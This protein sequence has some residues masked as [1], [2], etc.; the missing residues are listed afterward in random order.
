MLCFAYNFQHKFLAPKHHL[1]KANFYAI[2]PY[3]MKRAYTIE[4]KFNFFGE[5]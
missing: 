3:E 4:L 5:L 2:H 1:H